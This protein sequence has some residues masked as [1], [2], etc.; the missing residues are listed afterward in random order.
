MLSYS[1]GEDGPSAQLRL[2]PPLPAPP[3]DVT[4]WEPMDCIWR[5]YSTAGRLALRVVDLTPQADG[6]VRIAA[7][8]FGSPATPACTWD[9]LASWPPWLSWAHGPGS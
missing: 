4:A 5:Y 6:I 9:D 3:D 7:V 8:G 2:I 1:T